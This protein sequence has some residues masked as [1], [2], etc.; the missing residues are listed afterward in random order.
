M[1]VGLYAISARYSLD[2]PYS[3]FVYIW[4]LILTIRALLINPSTAEVQ[5][6]P[7]TSKQIF[8]FF[9][10]SIYILSNSLFEHFVSILKFCQY[11]EV[12]NL[13]VVA[14]NQRN[15]SCN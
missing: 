13:E 10:N 4:A 8:G 15:H 11:F 7:Y 6:L 5:V 14:K 12:R 1:P 9:M 3:I 2:F